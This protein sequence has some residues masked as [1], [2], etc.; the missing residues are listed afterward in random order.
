[1]SSTIR[2]N[3]I[4]SSAASD[5]TL[6]EYKPQ[7]P[8]SYVRPSDSSSSLISDQELDI[9]NPPQTATENQLSTCCSDC[10]DNCF[11]S[12]SGEYCTGTD[13]NFCGAALA[14]LCCRSAL[15]YGISF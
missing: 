6:P 2:S 15:A 13:K 11:G 8:P 7:A 14:A 5:D 10:W 3:F 12:C 4:K 1:M 9:E